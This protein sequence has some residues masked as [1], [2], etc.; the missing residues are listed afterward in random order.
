[1]NIPP[2][3]L[4]PKPDQEETPRKKPLDSPTFLRGMHAA[5]VEAVT[6]RDTEG[7]TITDPSLRCALAAQAAQKFA[8]SFGI[9]ARW[10]GN[11]MSNGQGMMAVAAS[12]LPRDDQPNAPFVLLGVVPANN[13][14]EF[15]EN[16]RDAV[17]QIPLHEAANARRLYR[18]AEILA[19]SLDGDP[20]ADQPAGAIMLVDTP[21]HGS[22]QEFFD[23]LGLS[24]TWPGAKA[25]GMQGSLRAIL[26]RPVPN[27]LADYRTRQAAPTKG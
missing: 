17:N 6:P 13:N 24:V 26:V 20:N 27:Y 22:G 11:L 14:L 3:P 7:K 15:I 21:S 8:Q 2:I 16:F 4:G 9:E 23:K 18:G 10:V 19:A 25:T 1:M 5:A 12:A